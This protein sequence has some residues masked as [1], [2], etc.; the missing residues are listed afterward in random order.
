L[1][2]VIDL[3][4]AGDE[5]RG[6]LSAQPHSSLAADDLAADPFRVSHAAIY[7]IAGAIDHL[8]CLRMLIQTAASL[9]T[10]APFTLNRDR[11]RG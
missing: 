2:E 7:G 9:H 5:Q 3:W 10:F 1:F 8:H 11:G 4:Q 6:R